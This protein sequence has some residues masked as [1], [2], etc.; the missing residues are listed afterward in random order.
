MPIQ[1]IC[2]GFE[3][4]LAVKLLAGG[5]SFTLS[6]HLTKKGV[7]LSGEYGFILGEGT[8]TEE[9][10]SGSVT[11]GVVTIIKRGL[12]PEDPETEVTALKFDHD[13]S[14]SVKITDYPFLGL[15]RKYLGGEKAL[16]APLK[17]ATHQTPTEDTELVDKKYVQELLTGEIATANPSAAGTVFT[18]KDMGTKPIVKTILAHEHA[19]PDMTIK[20][21]PFSLAGT[22]KQINFI[23]GDSPVFTAPTVNPRIDILVYDIAAA[24]L[25]IRV[26]EENASPVAPVLESGDVAIANVYHRVGE[27]VI[28]NISD[29]TNGYILNQ[30][31]LNVY[32][33][34]FM[35]S[36]DF[37]LAGNGSDGNVT[38]ATD[39]TLTR[40]M[41]YNNL[42]INAGVTLYPSGWRVF[43]KNTLLNNGT[44]NYDGAN[45]TIGNSGGGSLGVG[46]AGG[47]VVATGPMK[48]TA[49]QNGNN[50]GNIAT[51]PAAGS[52]TAAQIALGGRSG[53]GGKGG[54]SGQAGNGANAGAAG[55]LTADIVNIQPF[56]SYLVAGSENIVSDK[57]AAYLW[58]INHQTQIKIGVA[59]SGGGGGGGGTGTYGSGGGGGGATGGTI[60]IV[61]TTITNNGI[62]TAK[63]GNGGAGANG[64]SGG[65][66]WGPGGGGG[67]GGGGAIILV[68]KNITAGT[69]VVTAGSGGAGGDHPGYSGGSY[70][71]VAGAAG[72][73]G[74]HYKL[75]MG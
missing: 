46:G 18:D 44:I 9:W 65:S 47:A 8:A 4:T 27:T 60:L 74:S 71:G 28:K 16:P 75:K 17:Y 10:I 54:D 50:G 26:G 53:A 24:A 21:A 52:A 15:V 20:V 59:A 35:I 51:T 66:Y 61:A 68:Y 36:S 73:V 67:G 57:I 56:E 55:A 69:I 58:S 31:A 64:G 2:A 33:N 25:E 37:L 34:D 23:G 62:I 3:T 49:G 40:D 19:A 39:T 6:N 14:S 72:L 45:G 43:V 48:N 5:T 11:D 12:D 63:G 22:D 70:E 1:K 29:S 7:E 41:Y 42:T 32:R 13:R 38:L 30:Y